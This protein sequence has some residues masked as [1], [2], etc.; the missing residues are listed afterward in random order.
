MK[1]WIGAMALMAV[2][3]IGDAGTIGIASAA[4]VI[5][6]PQ[7]TK[8]VPARA[9]RAYRQDG[10][11]YGPYDARLWRMDLLLWPALLLRARAVPARLRF[12]L[13]VVVAGR[14]D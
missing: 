5:T 1:T 7:R 8:F 10:A 2:L 12:R 11:G 6:V 13:R 14:V 3:A 4:K 9:H